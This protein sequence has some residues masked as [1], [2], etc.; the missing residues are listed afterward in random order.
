MIDLAKMVLSLQEEL[1]SGPLKEV[2]SGILR[3]IVHFFMEH[4]DVTEEEVAI[5]FTNKQKTNL[6]FAYP[7]YL[8]NSGV[9][10]IDSTDAIVAQIY[11]TGKSFIDNKFLEKE[12]LSMFEFIKTPQSETKLI[13]KMIGAQIVHGDEKLGVVEIS[14]RRAAYSDVGRDF[15]KEDLDLLVSSLHQFAPVLK[16]LY[17]EIFKQK[18]ESVK[19]DLALLAEIIRWRRGIRDGD[20]VK[21]RHT[22]LGMT[23]IC[24]GHITHKYALDRIEVKTSSENCKDM[25]TVSVDCL[26]PTSWDKS[27][28]ARAVNVYK[29]LKKLS[30][31]VGSPD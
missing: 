29:R 13:W 5:F 22:Y 8:A 12:H 21:I 26:W 17:D 3:H 2:K 30:K 19:Q 15:T 16:I 11:R 14:R 27:K 7:E 10:P 24:K 4:M 31:I 18:R 9:I 6:S 1:K 23:Q 25:M 20:A 28:M